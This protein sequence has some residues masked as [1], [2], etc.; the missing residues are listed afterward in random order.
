MAAIRVAALSENRRDAD[1][2][3]T[4]RT[5]ITMERLKAVVF[6]IF[7]LTREQSSE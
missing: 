6:E 4:Y 7:E 5:Q 1:Y 3:S 2:L